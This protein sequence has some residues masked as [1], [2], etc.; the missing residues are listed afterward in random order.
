MFYQVD[1]ICQHCRKSVSALGRDF[2]ILDT[3]PECGMEPFGIKRFAGLVYVVS[4]PNQ[5]GVKIGMTEKTIDQRIKGL[6]S[7][8]VPGSFQPIAVFPSKR[9]RQDEKRIHDKLARKRIAKE[10]FDLEP[11]DAVLKC[12]RI[13]NRRNP[14][15]FDD[16]LQEKFCKRL[17]IAKLE[18]QLRLK[19]GSEL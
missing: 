11:I 17:E 16:E 2:S 9:P 13:L 15:F 6:N 3:C 18:M 12:F 14:V 5:S 4:N 8:G 19:G 10:H 7:S 1:G